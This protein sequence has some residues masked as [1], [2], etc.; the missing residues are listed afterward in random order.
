V[1][2]ILLLAHW[3]MVLMT[4]G[5]LLFLVFAVVLEALRPGG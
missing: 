1:K 4:V 5:V 2:V 3:A